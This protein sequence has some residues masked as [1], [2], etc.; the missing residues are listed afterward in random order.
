MQTLYVTAI[1]FGVVFVSF[2]LI[3]IGNLIKKR[4]FRGGCASNN[5]LLKDKF[6]SCTVCGKQPSEDCKMPEV[7]AP[8]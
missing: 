3:N 5:P 1:V 4:E 7:H 2:M 8:Q 6:G